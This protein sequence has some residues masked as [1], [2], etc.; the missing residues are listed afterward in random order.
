MRSLC[1][2]G[3]NPAL[4]KKNDC[5]FKLLFYADSI[6]F[7]LLSKIILTYGESMIRYT[8]EYRKLYTRD[9]K[10]KNK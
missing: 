4:S 8:V 10:H 1:P 6:G 3:V 5:L 2:G 9:M 7:D